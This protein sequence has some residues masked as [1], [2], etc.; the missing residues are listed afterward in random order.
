[1]ATGRL[2]RRREPRLS[3]GLMNAAQSSHGVQQRSLFR[4]MHITS[5]GFVS[6]AQHGAF[7]PAITKE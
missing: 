3:Y 1:M 6:R 7:L 2:A 4:G 5:S